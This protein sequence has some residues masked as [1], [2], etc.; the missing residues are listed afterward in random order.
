MLSNSQVFSLINAGNIV[1]GLLSDHYVR[2]S[3]ELERFTDR[4]LGVPILVVADPTLFD[5]RPDDV[6]EVSPKRIVRF[7]YDHDN[8]SYTNVTHAFP[9]FEF[10]ANF[11]V[12]AKHQPFVESVVK[13]N[14]Q[15]R[16]FVHKI[17]ANH[18]R[19]GAF[20]TRNIPHHG[21]ERIMQRLLECCDHLVVNPVLGP[22]KS[23]DVTRECLVEVFENYFVAKYK[24]R[25]S[26]CPIIANMFYA[27]PREAI[28]HSIIRK[29][30]GFDIFTVGRDHAGA[31]N[32]YPATAAIETIKSVVD[33]LGID[34]MCHGGA[35]FCEICNEIVL[36]GDCAHGVESVKDIS[37]TAFRKCLSNGEIFQMA[38][39]EMQKKIFKE[40]VRIFEE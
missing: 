15:S 14:Q 25:I 13:N 7:V 29:K 20:Q 2:S 1:S 28:H 18:G 36:V 6:F 22:K 30:L 17:K 35:G 32:I 9:K 10:L 38:D 37:G 33:D 19:V 34:V 27:G 39:K 24:G 11:S 23:G 16:E 3:V 26:F 4:L 5:Y 8:V 21:H 31:Q 12:K 40:D